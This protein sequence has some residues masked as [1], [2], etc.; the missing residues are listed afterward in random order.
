MKTTVAVGMTILALGLVGFGQQ[1]GINQTRTIK[2]DPD[3]GFG[4]GVPWDTMFQAADTTLALL[5]DGSFFRGAEKEGRIHKFDPSGALIKSFGQIGQG[6][7]DLQAIRNLGILD[8][9]YLLVNEGANRLSVFDLDGRF[10]KI[11]ASEPSIYALTVLGK[12]KIGL[13]V[14]DPSY[15]RSPKVFAVSYRARIMDVESGEVK[16]LANFVYTMPPPQRMFIKVFWTEVF[17]S[18]IASDKMAVAFSGDSRVSIYNLQG[19]KAG[20]F[21]LN[22]DPVKLT[23]EHLEF[24]THAAT[25]PKMR[26]ILTIYKGKISLPEYLPRFLKMIID[27]G[28]RILI[29]E[30]NQARL[31]EE[32]AFQTFSPEGRRLSRTILTS[33][34]Y[35]PAF[36]L[37]FHQGYA[38]GSLTKKDADGTVVF[39]R[40]KIAD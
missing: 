31:T 34:E 19:E 39:A 37:A 1:P 17:L 13:I 25:D 11:I 2:I 3:P 24:A 40:W 23:W 6:P 10:V 4:L 26:E 36:P 14:N 16:D 28:G 27:P 8:E 15:A 7:G 32:I 29:R 20:G 38:Y 12:N 22:I 30:N 5:P 35:Q 9:K 33:D 21:D 18:P